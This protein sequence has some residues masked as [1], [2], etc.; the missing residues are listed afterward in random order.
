MLDLLSTS[1]I[2][3]VIVAVILMFSL[4]WH[5]L[6]HAWVANRMGDPTA[7]NLGRI[8][9]NPL[10]HLDPLGSILILVMGFGW[11]KPVPIQPRNFT[12]LRSGLFWVSIAGVLVNFIV[13][14][15]CL[16]I[17]EYFLSPG[18]DM[19]DF[20]YNTFDFKNQQHFILIQALLTAARI[21][22]LLVLFNLIPIP[23]LDG[24]KVVQA[25][26]PMSWWGPMRQLER[27]GFIAVL[28]IV[29]LSGDKLWQAIDFVIRGI[30]IVLP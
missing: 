28:A 26:A 21:N 19:K 20:S 14:L 10:N 22:I 18:L 12:N 5:E 30:Y 7:K 25:F 16:I 9:L 17:L 23:P 8:T 15:L 27:Y 11:A 6:G 1:P 4:A 13:A 3:F 24:S 29:Y 2:T